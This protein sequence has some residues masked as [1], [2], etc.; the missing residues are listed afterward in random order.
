MALAISPA[1]PSARGLPMQSDTSLETVHRLQALIRRETGAPLRAQAQTEMA[2]IVRESLGLSGAGPELSFQ[3]RDVTVLMADLR[4]FTA[5]SATQPAGLI[6]GMLNRCLARMSEVVFHYGGTI[7]K[8][9]GDAIMVLFGAPQTHADDVGHALACAVEMQ[10]AMR[11]LNTEYQLE[12][13]PELYMGIGINTGEVM[14]GRF[15]S[16][17][18]SEYTV[19]GNEVNLASRIEAFSLRGQV[20]ISEA[21]YQ[22]CQGSVLATPPVAVYVKGKAQPVLLRELIEIPSRHLK[23]PRQELRRSHR[24]EV[25]MPC[26]YQRIQNKIV[27]PHIT[28]SRVRDIGYSGVLIEADDALAVHDEV[29][30]EFDLSLVD[31]RAT[32][33]YATVV[34]LKL[35]EGQFMAG[36][37]FT[38]IPPEANAR[39]ELFVQLLVGAR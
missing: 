5:L 17:A 39:I 31:Y 24:V 29:K 3:R 7:D 18:Y 38:S 12:N 32:E 6:I 2:K 37:E 21:T 11:D 22:R 13:M 8:F 9:M 28:R 19:I 16:A 23:V 10:I 15:G 30:L 4:G 33:I 36:L 14:A 1:T 26:T 27:V 35:Q 34:N 20:L 25:K